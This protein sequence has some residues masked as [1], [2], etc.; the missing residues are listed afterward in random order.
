MLFHYLRWFRALQ[1]K[2]FFFKSHKGKLLEHTITHV[3]LFYI[4]N[5]HC[6]WMVMPLTSHSRHRFKYQSR[7]LTKIGH[8]H[9]HNLSNSSHSMLHNLRSWK[10]ELL[11]N[12]QTHHSTV[13]HCNAA[14]HNGH[15]LK[16]S[17]YECQSY[18]VRFV[19]WDSKS[20]T[21]FWVIWLAMVTSMRVYKF[22]KLIT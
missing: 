14:K 2:L 12:P 11:N 19:C 1:L 6:T 4:K 18:A 21:L 5:R 7:R 16:L 13:N 10:R 3:F 9:F 8:E 15:S 20:S 17:F 22:D